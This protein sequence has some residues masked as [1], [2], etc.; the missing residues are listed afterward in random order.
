MSVFGK[1]F[2][3]KKPKFKANCAIGKFPME[4]GDG[5]LLTTSQI[6]ASKKYWDS[7]MT[8]PETMSYTVQHFKNNDST[9]TQMRGMIFEKYSSE[10]KP[11]LISDS[12]ISLFEVDKGEA[13]QN[14]QKWWETEG[15][16]APDQSGAA[17]EKMTEDT[18]K[19][20]KSYAVLEAGRDK[21]H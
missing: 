21:V 8:H 6:I 1:L 5:Y 3:K 2:G 12:Y 15:G 16:F 19:E 9:A 10:E 11:W 13:R 17:Q 18:F 7:I 4:S 14:A 20:I